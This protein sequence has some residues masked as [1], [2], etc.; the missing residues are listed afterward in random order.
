MA[1]SLPASFSDA[2][3]LTPQGEFSE[4]DTTETKLAII[5]SR[6]TAALATII[7]ARAKLRSATRFGY[8]RLF[9]HSP[10]LPTLITEGHTERLQQFAP[11]FIGLS[12]SNDCYIHPANMINSVVIDLRKYN[13]LFNS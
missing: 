7:F 9:R 8:H 5:A 3:N 6:P 2:G 10:I 4:T 13:L 11:L 1:I 12:R